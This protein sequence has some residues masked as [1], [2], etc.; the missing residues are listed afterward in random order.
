MSKK[1]AMKNKQN[2]KNKAEEGKGQKKTGPLVLPLSSRS[3]GKCRAPSVVRPEG[4][5][6]LPKARRGNA[7][8]MRERNPQKI[9]RDNATISNPLAEDD[10]KGLASGVK[11]KRARR[12]PMKR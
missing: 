6:T 10:W 8:T 4:A 7:I 2:R 9:P 3:E 11:N 12:T 1:A 5:Q